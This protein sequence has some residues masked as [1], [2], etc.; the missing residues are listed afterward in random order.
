MV[1]LFQ[2]LLGGSHV[3]GTSLSRNPLVLFSV[4]LI[5]QC[6]FLL[7]SLVSFSISCA[8]RALLL[9]CLV[10]GIKFS[11]RANVSIS[12]FV[13]VFLERFSIVLRDRNLLRL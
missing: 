6:I 2:G 10:R 8:R 12:S 5:N 13:R 3:E 1:F 9:C 4:G 7:T 11:P